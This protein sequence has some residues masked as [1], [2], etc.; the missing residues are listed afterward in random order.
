MDFPVRRSEPVSGPPRLAQALGAAPLEVYGNSFNYLAVFGDERTLRGLT[1]DLPAIAG[2]DR[3]G[4]I[5]TAP[6]SDGYD[7]VSRYFAPA[8]GIPEDPV[9]GAAHTMLIPYWAR[10][11]GRSEL[12]AYQ[13]SSRGGE[14]VCRLRGERIELEGSCVFY[15]EGLAEI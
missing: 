6:G 11:L 3:N 14:M 2:L 1:P 12:R 5:V 4:V 10:R 7:C 9:T 13:T 8:K 15:L